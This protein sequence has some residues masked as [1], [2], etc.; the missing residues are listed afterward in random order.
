MVVGG[1]YSG[2]ICVWDTRSKQTP[3][4]RTPLS[5][6]GHTNP[7]FGMEIIGNANSYNL[8]SLS[9]D[10]RLCIWNLDKL[11]QPQES[12]DL[13]MLLDLNEDSKLRKDI[14]AFAMAFPFGEANRFFVGSEDGSVY[15]ANKQAG[16]KIGINDKYEGHTGPITS[17]D[18]HPPGQLDGF[19]ELFLTSSMDW[20]VKLWS[21][22]SLKPI[23]SFEEYD[24]YVYDARWSPIHPALFA[25]VD[26]LGRLRLWNIN[27]NS[28]QPIF[29]AEIGNKAS[30]L[31]RLRWSADGKKIIVGNSIG[32]LF[33]YEL[34][35]QV[36]VP[37]LF[38][39]CFFR[40]ISSSSS[41][42]SLHSLKQMIGKDS[43]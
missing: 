20:T 27:E 39:A 26:G 25:T 30:A 37:F 35:S 43:K 22:K 18:F 31:N 13:Y 29:S 38:S 2:Q 7:I 23:F 16:G 32:N 1:T 36:C 42:S 28:E 10:G 40:L 17:I 12:L 24:E 19:T 4:Q 5:S 21:Q 14:A 15:I 8:V 41:S 9:T 34:D 11:N 33:V 3:V 6:G